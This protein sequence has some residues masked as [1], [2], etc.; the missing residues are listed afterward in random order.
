MD[1]IEQESKKILQYNL[2][3]CESFKRGI[4]FSEKPILVNQELPSSKNGYVDNLVLVCVKNKNKDDGI[5]LWDV[6]AFDG[7]SWSA[8]SNTWEE[9]IGWRPIIRE[10]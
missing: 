2:N 6:C 4:L 10:K 9:I 8:R 7:E 3:V 1:T 5:L